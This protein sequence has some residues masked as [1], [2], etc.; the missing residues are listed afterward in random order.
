MQA[1]RLSYLERK[2]RHE[3]TNEF[4]M[5]YALFTLSGTQM[6]SVDG[7]KPV[8]VRWQT[9]S[10][11]VTAAS[12][13]IGLPDIVVSDRRIGFRNN[14]ARIARRVNAQFGIH[15]NPEEM[16]SDHIFD[17]TM[18]KTS[19]WRMSLKPTISIVFRLVDSQELGAAVLLL[20]IKPYDGPYRVR[21]PLAP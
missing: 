19:S 20:G 1:T 15:L 18:I 5:G 12:I 2:R 8:D 21:P 16:G 9:L 10:M 13:D 11:L 7:P 14:V 4:T 6:V 3:F 17:N